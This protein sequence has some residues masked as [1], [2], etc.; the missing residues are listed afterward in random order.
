MKRA[1][2]HWQGAL[3]LAALALVTWTT[4][5][6]QVDAAS[7]HS[8][9]NMILAT[10][11][12]DG[13]VEMVVALDI[14]SGT[15]SG[16]VMNTNTRKFFGSYVTR[17]VNADLQ[18]PKG[19]SPKYTLVTG[20]A[21]FKANAAGGRLGSCVIYIAEEN[22]GNL[23]AYAVQWESSILNTPK[24]FNNQPFIKLGMVKVGAGGP[25]AGGA[26]EEGN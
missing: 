11:T 7:T 1:W 10:A 26:T 18:V 23:M 5:G 22:S 2:N 8:S 15:L 20:G 4:S 19:K 14:V 17:T 16:H 6:S 24:G 13:Q 12:L 3:G 25:K 21:S 9:E